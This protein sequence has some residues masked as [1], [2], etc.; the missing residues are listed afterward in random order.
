[1][2]HTNILRTLNIF[3]IKQCKEFLSTKSKWLSFCAVNRPESVCYAPMCSLHASQFAP[4]RNITHT[5]SPRAAPT[6]QRRVTSKLGSGRWPSS[7][8]SSRAH[9]HFNLGKRRRAGIAAEAQEAQTP[10]LWHLVMG[11]H[12]NSFL[13]E[14]NMCCGSV[15][16][17]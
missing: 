15:I 7:R 16:R 4:E 9:F 8:C 3:A 6:Q 5:D 1:M 17:L 14:L 11:R 12:L 2:A 10:F 13:G